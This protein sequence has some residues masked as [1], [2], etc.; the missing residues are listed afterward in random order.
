MSLAIVAKISNSQGGILE[1]RLGKVVGQFIFEYGLI[2]NRYCQNFTLKITL[3]LISR[4][5][6]TIFLLNATQK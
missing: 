3:Y 2:K 1:V 4:S 5:R 6:K